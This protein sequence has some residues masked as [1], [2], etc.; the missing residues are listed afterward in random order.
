MISESCCGR[1]TW[2]IIIVDLDHSWFQLLY[3]KF[4][5]D[6]QWVVNGNSWNQ[7]VER[8]DKKEWLFMLAVII[9]Y[10]NSN[11]NTVLK[12]QIRTSLRYMSTWSSLVSTRSTRRA[13]FSC[14]HNQTAGYSGSN[15]RSGFR[16]D[17]MNV[18]PSLE[19]KKHSDK[20]SPRSKTVDPG[21]NQRAFWDPLWPYLLFPPCHYIWESK[22]QKL[23]NISTHT[24]TLLHTP[25][26][27]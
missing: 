10:S 3:W 23:Y 11:L 14:E 4:L 8:K 18:Q 1:V 26:T 20:N 19:S 6:V 24:Q 15:D 12:G 2:L 13:V 27:E 17:L 7:L 22:D 9:P 21:Q 25:G 5:D 16:K